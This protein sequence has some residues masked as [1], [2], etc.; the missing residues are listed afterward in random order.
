MP[1][2]PRQNAAQQDHGLE[3]ILDIVGLTIGCLFCIISAVPTMKSYSC[4]EQQTGE[5]GSASFLRLYPCEGSA[6]TRAAFL[7][8][9]SP[10]ILRNLLSQHGQQDVWLV[11]FLTFWL[12]RVAS[13]ICLPPRLYT[14][15]AAP[16]LTF[17]ARAS[18]LVLL[19]AAG[20]KSPLSSAA[21]LF[22]FRNHGLFDA[23]V[24]VTQPVRALRS[25]SR[26]RASQLDDEHPRLPLCH[27]L[28]QQCSAYWSFHNFV[29][30][31]AY[32]LSC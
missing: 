20:R 8:R 12:L 2:E 32:C 3:S 11:A 31:H 10:C 26:L 29:K 6:M 5:S 9:Y 30:T 13:R 21:S 22:V 18:P 28:P 1:V 17:A 4:N 23:I 27:P 14:H 15:L 7:A 25:S 16:C 24:S 19:L